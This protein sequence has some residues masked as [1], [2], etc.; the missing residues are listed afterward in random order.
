[1]VIGAG[2]I[3]ELED[4]VGRI[5]LMTVDENYQKRGIGKT[6]ITKLED[7]AVGQNWHTIR[8]WA[9]KNAI[10]FYN[11]INYKIVADGYLLF[12]VIEHKIMEKD[13]RK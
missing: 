5:L 11:K 9:R 6:I 8:L 10:D 7:Y 2:C 13:I 12:G 1:M 3:H 4:G